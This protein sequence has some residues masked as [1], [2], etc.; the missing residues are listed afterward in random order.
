MWYVEFDPTKKLLTLRL[1]AMVTAQGVRQLMR[2]HAQA[3]AATG[4]SE[5]GVLADLRGLAP[6]DREAANLFSEIKRSA[7]ALPGFRGRAVL[8]DSATIAL[9]QKRTS[10]DMDAS[11]FELVTTDEGEALQHLRNAM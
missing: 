2:A 1:G 8:V 3:L 7:V 6:L 10:M 5:F 4:G 11:Q 9:Q